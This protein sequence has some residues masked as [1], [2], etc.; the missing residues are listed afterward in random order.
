[1]SPRPAMSPQD[2]QR[3]KELFLKA[4]ALRPQDRGP[5]L[6]SACA[7]NERVREEVESLLAHAPTSAVEDLPDPEAGR[8]DEEAPRQVPRIPDY[9]LI[10]PIGRGGIG[11]VWLARNRVDGS[12]C[13]V[14]VFSATARLELEGVREYK[15]RVADHPHLVR[16][17]HVG[18]IGDTCYY[19]MPLA[20]DACATS[21]VLDPHQYEPLTLARYLERHGRMPVDQVLVLGRQMLSALAHLQERGA[22]HG[23]VKPANIIRVRGCWQLADHGLVS[24]LEG[25][26]PRGFTVAYC[27]PEGPGGVGADLYA[28]GL[29]LLQAATGEGGAKLKELLAAAREEQLARVIQRACAAEPSQRFSRA[30]D[31]LEALDAVAPPEASGPAARRWWAWP[32][33]AVVVV[34]GVGILSSWPGRTGT[35]PGSPGSGAPGA[36]VAAPLTILSMDLAHFRAG[37]D[38]PLGM[39]GVDST[40]ARFNEDSIGVLVRFSA[41]AYCYILAL[42][43]DGTTQLC[44]PAAA[45]EV[46]RP[47]A[48]VDAPMGVDGEAKLFGLTDGIGAQAFAVVASRHPLPAYSEW[49]ARA[50]KLPWRSFEIDGVWSSD[51]HEPALLSQTRGTIQPR[52]PNPD[53][54]AASI[55]ALKGAPGIESVRAV[56]FPVRAAVPAARRESRE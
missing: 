29:T 24:N 26:E 50:G 7:G 19:V 20:D 32:V 40:G 21:P 17:E 31:M 53:P 33:A 25:S 55:A 16:I 45:D 5:L 22:R 12:H 10:A 36:A 51:G 35:G 47:S 39:I 27:P 42:N 23:D 8:A 54:F 1:M 6:H 49:S 37:L 44:Y 56:A 13:A 52:P 28:L 2:F 34:L 30:R 9:E 38:R 43:P 15:R 48:V 46:P 4:C 18:M 14:K 3:A 11:E 41:A